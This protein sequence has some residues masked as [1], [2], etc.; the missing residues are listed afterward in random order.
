VSYYC[1]IDLD[2]ISQYDFIGKNEVH[3]SIPP[4][5][6][7]S[8]KPVNNKADLSPPQVITAPFYGQ[9]TYVQSKI[10][11]GYKPLKLPFVPHDY[12]PKFLDYLPRF[13]G[14]DHVTIKQ[15]M[16]SFEWFTDILQ[17]IHED[18]FMITFFQSLSGDAVFW[19]INLKYDSISSW[20][21]LCNVILRY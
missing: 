4:K 19:F 18:V 9:L 2:L 17:I 7:P 13:N 15:H 20:T 10:R 5:V 1:T 16:V 12:P 14:E 8:C 21:D 6:D 3:I 11:E